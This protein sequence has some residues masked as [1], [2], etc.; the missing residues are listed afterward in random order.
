MGYRAALILVL[1]NRDSFTFNLVQA[2]QELGAQVEVAR[3]GDLSAHEVLQRR[4]E[5]VLLGPGPGTPAGA[6][7]S[8][9]LVRLLEGV[10]LLGVCLGHQALATA[11]GGQLVRDEDLCHGQ[12]RPV[13]HDG[14]GLFTGLPNPLALTRYNS[15]RVDEASL[16]SELE[17]SAR[18]PR[19]EIAGL[20]HRTRPLEGVQGH[21]ESM[22]CVDAGGRALLSNFVSRCGAASRTP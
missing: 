21:P 2:L 15:L 6:G 16:P 11:L 7:C 19:G 8:E 22:L 14:R 20:R 12:T 3:A 4:P 5:G 10:P 1:D 18:G 9:E 17:V 13:T